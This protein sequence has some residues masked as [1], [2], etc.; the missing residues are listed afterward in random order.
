VIPSEKA[1]AFFELRDNELFVEVGSGFLISMLPKERLSD[2][3]FFK[4]SLVADQERPIYFE[5]GKAEDR[6]IYQAAAY[7]RAVL[8]QRNSDL[9]LEQAP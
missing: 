9:A 1:K 2:L 5:W 7:I 3:I 4:F 6:K 8:S